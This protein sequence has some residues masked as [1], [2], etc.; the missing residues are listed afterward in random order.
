MEV[1]GHFW[2]PAAY[3]RAN[4][5]RHPLGRRLDGPWIRCDRCGEERNLAPACSL[6]LYRL[7]YTEFLWEIRNGCICKY[8]IYMYIC[9]NWCGRHRINMSPQS[10]EA[11]PTTLPPL[12]K[13]HSHAIT[14]IHH[15]SFTPALDALWAQI[16]TAT[17]N[18]PQERKKKKKKASK[19]T[20]PRDT[21]II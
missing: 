10:F 2:V 14:S 9:R 8:Y 5:H 3:P 6:S 18:D 12:D 16:L 21:W 11:N 4:I 7:S 20:S 15:S 17:L 13:Y 19:R 1:C